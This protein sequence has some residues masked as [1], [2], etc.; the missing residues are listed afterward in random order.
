MLTK[1]EEKKSHQRSSILPS[2]REA[3]QTLFE[4]VL[5]DRD[6]ERVH[7]LD[8]SAKALIEEKDYQLDQIARDVPPELFSSYRKFRTYLYRFC[9]LLHYLEEQPAQEAITVDTA[10]KVLLVMKHLEEVNTRRAFGK[11]SLNVNEQLV[12]KVLDKLNLMGGK[13]KPE[14]IKNCLRKS[15][16]GKGNC[17]RFL[18]QMILKVF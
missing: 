2:E 8:D 6:Q 11:A 17:G 14:Q 3:V 7:Q 15:F 9:L 5:A 12:Q 1:P 16:L 10:H 13:A 4:R 18:D